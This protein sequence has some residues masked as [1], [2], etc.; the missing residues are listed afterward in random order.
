MAY[1][2]G[3][4]VQAVRNGRGIVA[5]KSF[6]PG[7]PVCEIKGRIVTPTTVW[8]YWDSDRQRAENCFRYSAERYLDP[9]GGIGAY[10]NHACD[11][12][13]GLVKDGRR[14]L[15]KAIAPIARG[16]EVTFDY[17]TQLGADDVWTMHCNC[18]AARCRGTVRHAGT[19]PA[20]VIRRY[21]AL[22]VMPAFIL[23]TLPRK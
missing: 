7:A 1:P 19:L 5:L 11:P 9:D 12:N 6:A 14:L 4:T 15:L 18:G 21:R 20:A 8:G 17:A 22:G 10:A 3:L 23:R 16:D 13:A 2:S